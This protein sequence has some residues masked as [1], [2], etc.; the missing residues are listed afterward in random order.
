[1]L[2]EG[3]VK[4][5]DLHGYEDGSRSLSFGWGSPGVSLQ[6]GCL[7][8][9]TGHECCGGVIAAS[10]PIANSKTREMNEA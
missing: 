6:V 3:S 2:A 9:A 7:S 8:V 4:E 10:L 1:M 5:Q